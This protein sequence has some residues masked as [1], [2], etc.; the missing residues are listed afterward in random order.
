MR[1]CFFLIKTG[2]TEKLTKETGNVLKRQPD[3]RAENSI[4]PPISSKQRE[5]PTP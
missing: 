3:K 2:K 5:N 4:R 1:A